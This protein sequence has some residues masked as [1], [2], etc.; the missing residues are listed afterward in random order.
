M[1][2]LLIVFALF[3]SGSVSAQTNNCGGV[4]QTACNVA[5]TSGGGGPVTQG[6]SPWVTSIPDVRALDQTINSATLSA[7]YTVPVNGQGEVGLSISGLTASTAVLTPECTNNIGA[8][9]PVWAG[10]MAISGSSLNT[11]ITADGAYR[12]ESGGRTGVRLRVTTTG[13]GTITV[14]STAA[15]TSS[16]S[17]MAQSL[18]AGSNVIGHVVADTGSTTA[19]TSLPGSPMQQTGGTVTVNPGQRTLVPLD[20]ASVTTGGSAVTALAAG[21]ATAGGFIYNPVVATVALCIN[22]IGVA[23][24]VSSAGNTTCIQPGQPYNIV[25]SANAV[26]V[27]SSDSTHAFSGMGLQ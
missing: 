12:I 14:S 17:T 9:S 18:P 24:G 27:I 4:G 7:A 16:L 13:T 10:C 19:V 6:T 5:V 3:L 11:T 2:V 20:I 21:H 8:A 1:R 26:S 15:A 25:P 22:Q 23:S